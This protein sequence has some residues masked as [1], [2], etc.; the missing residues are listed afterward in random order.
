M[1]PKII[2]NAFLTGDEINDIKT[3]V[4]LLRD[5]W[6]PLD[7]SEKEIF[8]SIVVRMMPSGTYASSFTKEEIKANNQLMH[9]NFSIYYTKIREKLSSYYSIPVD[10]SHELQLPGFHIFVTDNVKNVSYP[11]LNFHKDEFPKHFSY[12]NIDSFVIPISLPAS[13]GSLLFNNPPE[14][15]PYKEGMMAV[16]PGDLIHSIEP[17]TFTD[18]TECRITMQMHVAFGKLPRPAKKGIIFW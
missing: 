11:Y 14:I 16:W 10:Y 13:G 7:P 6:V 4:L 1:I 9:N 12:H 18:S 8:D 17:F 2:D 5:H 3:K 15:F